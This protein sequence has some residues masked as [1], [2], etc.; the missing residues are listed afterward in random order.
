MLHTLPSVRCREAPE[1]AAIIRAESG[2][3]ALASFV[4]FDFA[5][6]FLCGASTMIMLRPSCFA[7]DSMKPRS[8]TS[9]ANFSN[10]RN[11]SSGRDCSRPRNMI[12]TLTLLP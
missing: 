2:L 3:G 8:A 12:V 7:F 1:R 10:R 5:L 11:P 4:A 9:S 6:G